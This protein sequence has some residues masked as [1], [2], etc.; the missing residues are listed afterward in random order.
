AVPLYTDIG[1]MYYR[2]DIIQ[3]LSHSAR[4]EKKLKESITWEEMIA[5][6]G[7]MSDT[8]NPFYVYPANNYEGLICS[9]VELLAGADQAIFQGDS[10][11]LNTPRAHKSL[12]LLK[13][14][15]HKYH[16]TPPE[17]VNF[18]EY[19]CYLFALENDGIFLRGWPGFL[20][21]YRNLVEDTSKFGKFGI[22]A[23]PHFKDSSPVSVIGGWNL[24]VS[25]FSNKKR[26]ALEFIKFALQQKS[27]ELLYDEGGFIPVR[28]SVYQD[29]AFLKHHQQLKYYRQL[30]E[31]GIHR[32]MMEDYTR[33]SD[34]ISYYVHLAIK[35]EVSVDAA[36]KEATR[37]IN[38]QKYV[39]K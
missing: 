35:G 32:P 9:F 18:D 17:V 26:E 5:L 22:A 36:L 15:I 29:T 13:D 37:L 4:L 16:L 25:K 19:K 14:L 30:L 20:R 28:L 38:E 34:I 6:H 10:V 23:L 33:F 12:T 11:Y 3:K 21:H 8:G 31:R 7:R 39:I 1:L 24:M 27:Q 2:K